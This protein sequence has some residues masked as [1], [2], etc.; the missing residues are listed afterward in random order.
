MYQ[1]I[2]SIYILFISIDGKVCLVRLDRLARSVRLQTDNFIC[3]FANK[4]TNEN[5]LFVQS[6]DSKR[7]EEKRL[8]FHF[9]FFV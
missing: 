2:Y 5:L 1:Y 9:P 4:L 7:I 3:F 8:S 6:A